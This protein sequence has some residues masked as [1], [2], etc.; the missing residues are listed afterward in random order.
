MGRNLTNC[1][2]GG[3]AKGGGALPGQWEGTYRCNGD[4]C[5]EA[6]RG[7][8][9]DVQGAR[10]FRDRSD[11]KSLA[12]FCNLS[13]TSTETACTRR[14]FLLELGEGMVY[15]VFRSRGDE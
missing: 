2:T 7:G 4:I 15:N 10:D 3:G 11:Y 14:A 13:P 12:D 9:F 5:W 6:R 1:P 8:M